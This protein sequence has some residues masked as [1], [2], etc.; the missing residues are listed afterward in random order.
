IGA[1]VVN[2]GLHAGIGIDVIAARASDLI[3]PGDLVVLATEALHDP[4]VQY[5]SPLRAEFLE[6]VAGKQPFYSLALA[7]KR[8]ALLR[9]T[10]D[11][12]LMSLNGQPPPSANHPTSVYSL[13]AIGPDGSLC[14]P[15][16]GARDLFVTRIT[17]AWTDADFAR[18]VATRA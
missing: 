13:E 7:R 5:H 18:S 9:Q 14:F 2:Y 6:H 11:T 12:R 16:P 17:G 3:G 8:C 15:R 1:P 10:L 4:L